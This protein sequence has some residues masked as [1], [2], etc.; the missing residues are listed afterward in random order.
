[1]IKEFQKHLREAKAELKGEAVSRARLV[2]NYTDIEGHETREES[3]RHA[4][5]RPTKIAVRMLDKSVK[6][7]F[8]DGSLRNVSVKGG[9]HARRLARRAAHAARMA[10]KK[11]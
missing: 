10:A 1:M 8:N 6:V 5:A 7:F 2:K 9:K 4:A 11:C 3:E